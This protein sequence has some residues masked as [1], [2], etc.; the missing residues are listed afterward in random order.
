[1][2]KYKFILVVFETLGITDNTKYV[3]FHYIFIAIFLLRIS[4]DIVGKYFVETLHN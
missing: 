4:I 3:E 1:M 2:Y